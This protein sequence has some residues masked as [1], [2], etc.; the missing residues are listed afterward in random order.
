MATPIIESIAENI[1][2]SISAITT[3]NGYNQ[4]LTGIRPKRSDFNNAAWNNYDV[5]VSQVE[6]EEG[7]GG[8]F[9]KEWQQFFM[10]TCIVIDSDTETESIDTNCN[11][12]AADIE[13]K[14]LADI[15]RGGLA[16]DTN[17]HAKVPFKDEQSAISGIA[18]QISVTYRTQENDPYNQA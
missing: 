13:K 16:I 9:T 12:V 8:A 15:T 4:N 11:K 14:L 2:T 1:K 10:L 5:I 18:V 7:Q 3:A 17:V 6:A